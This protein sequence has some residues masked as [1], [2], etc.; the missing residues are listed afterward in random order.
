MCKFWGPGHTEE[1][2]SAEGTGV[3]TEIPKKDGNGTEI[4][5]KNTL[6]SV[7]DN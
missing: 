6:L 3:N 7:L 4:S 2:Y 1:I 5:T